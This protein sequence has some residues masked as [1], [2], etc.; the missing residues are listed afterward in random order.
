[1]ILFDTSNILNIHK[2]VMEK[3]DIKCLEL[4]K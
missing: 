3:H 1:M 4:F 2:Y